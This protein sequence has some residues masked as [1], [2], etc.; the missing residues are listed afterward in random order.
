MYIPFLMVIILIFGFVINSNYITKDMDVYLAYEEMNNLDDIED[1][2]IFINR[3]ED[4]KNSYYDKVDLGILESDLSFLDYV[5]TNNLNLFKGNFSVL[6]F[7]IAGKV[8]LNDYKVVFYY[9]DKN[10]EGYYF[11]AKEYGRDINLNIARILKV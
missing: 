6:D 3:L 7:T 9:S 11:Y 5:K 8:N 10:E 2:T 4:Y 1:I